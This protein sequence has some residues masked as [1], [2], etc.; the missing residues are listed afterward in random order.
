M[1][2][3]LS[4]LAALVVGLC[5]VAYASGSRLARGSSIRPMIACLAVTLVAAF[6]VTNLALWLLLFEIAS[7]PLLVGLG[8]LSLRRAR[9]VAGYLLIGASLVAGFSILLAALLAWSDHGLLAPPAGSSLRREAAIVGLMA[10]AMAIKVPM[11]PL[12]YW[13]PEV[14][15]ESATVGSM[16]LAGVLLKLALYGFGRLTFAFPAGFSGLAPLLMVLACLGMLHS[17]LT[18]LRQVDLKRLIAY[19]SIGHINLLVAG[20]AS[21]LP[22]GILGSFAMASG[23]AFVSPALFLAAGLVTEALGSRS[24]RYTGGLMR[25]SPLLSLAFICLLLANAGVPGTVGFTGEAPLLAGLLLASPLLGLLA[26]VQISLGAA[27]ASWLIGRLCLGPQR[28][29]PRGASDTSALLLASLATMVEASIL[30]GTLGASSLTGTGLDSF[31]SM[32]LPN[33]RCFNPMGP[34]VID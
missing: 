17:M 22:M 31:A 28:V 10:L 23:H 2:A 6:A 24:L 13:L 15:G 32:A 21:G 4:L 7:L 26:A 20:L 30:G 5:L 12:H 9:L 16:L 18:I 14:H 3:G 19:A 11:V 33:L 25:L 27:F 1:G 8:V 34:W 29:Y